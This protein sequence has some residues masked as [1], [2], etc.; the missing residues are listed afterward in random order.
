MSICGDCTLFSECEREENF[1]L[2][3]DGDCLDSY[4]CHDKLTDL[5]YKLKEENKRL[6]LVLNRKQEESY[7]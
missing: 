3:C 6:K 2:A 7:E 1:G 5:I 4:E